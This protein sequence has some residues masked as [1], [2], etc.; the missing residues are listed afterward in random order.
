[1]I[2]QMIIMLAVGWGL[3]T[4]V[5]VTALIYRG[6]LQIHEEDQLFLDPAE[7]AIADQQQAVLTRIE[8]LNRPVKALF[9]AS[10]AL[11]VVAVGMWLW[12]GLTTF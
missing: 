12:Q 7:R 3:V 2:H 10:V 8:K 4:I 11:F 5:L 9:V 6:V 1:M